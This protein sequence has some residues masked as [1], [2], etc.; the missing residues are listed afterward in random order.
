MEGKCILRKVQVQ[1]S[2][3]T[4]VTKEW[5]LKSAD[6]I[7]HHHHQAK[8]AGGTRWGGGPGKKK[9]DGGKVSDSTGRAGE[10]EAKIKNGR[11]NVWWYYHWVRRGLGGLEEAGGEMAR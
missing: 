11:R 4:T 6:C 8:K 5:K 1:I 3:S 9:K 10:G 2:S 7:H